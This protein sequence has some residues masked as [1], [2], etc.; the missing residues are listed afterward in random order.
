LITAADAQQFVEDFGGI[1]AAL[2]VRM[3]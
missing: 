3:C 2:F 1:A